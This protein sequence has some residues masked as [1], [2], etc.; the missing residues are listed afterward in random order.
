MRHVARAF[1]APQRWLLLSLGV[2]ALVSA[3]KKDEWPYNLPAD[4]KYWPEEALQRRRNTTSLQE[5][6][7][8]QSSPHAIRMMGMDEGEKFFSEYWQ[9]DIG[10]EA[11]FLPDPAL[12]TGPARPT[13]AL[14]P[15]DG[16]WAEDW[17]EVNVSLP[18]N[19]PFKL[20]TED[21]TTFNPHFKRDSSHYASFF[22]RSPNEALAV[23]E[24][25]IFQCPTNTFD[26]SSIGRPNSC[27]AQ[28]EVCNIIQDT[29][30]GDVACCPV[31]A[32]CSG[33]VLNCDLG[34]TKCSDNLGGGC[35]IP[36]YVCIDIGCKWL[37]P[38]HVRSHLLIISQVVL[39][40]L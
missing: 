8:G 20:H 27:C 18:F 4:A 40:H 13:N 36:Q 12:E 30:L 34:F 31:N 10:E 11:G 14:R 33:S 15:R 2:L 16:T 32:L 6:S 21:Q 19:P 3:S 9:H 23:L 5:P 29:G 24:K 37:F 28:G 35:C 25:R 38:S 7:F 26:C 22:R 1:E 39:V 17:S